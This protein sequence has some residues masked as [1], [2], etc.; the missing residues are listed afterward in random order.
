MELINYANLNA[1]ITII[2][3]SRIEYAHN[4]LLKIVSN[5]LK[6]IKKLIVK[7]VPKLDILKA[8]IRRLV[9]RVLIN[10]ELVKLM[11]INV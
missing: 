3:M 9:H 7:L 11:Q 5:A 1:Q 10:V 2:K 8:Q 6:L 4:V